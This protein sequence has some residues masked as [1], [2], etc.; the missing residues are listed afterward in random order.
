[1]HGKY[2]GVVCHSLLQ[3]DC[4]TWTIK[5]AKHQRIDAIKLQ[6]SRRLLKVLWTARRSNYSILEEINPE[7]SLEG[8]MLKLQYFGHI[9]QRADQYF[10]HITQRANSLEMSLLL[11]KMEGRGWD[12][13]MASLMQWSWTWANFRRRWGTERPGVLQSMGSQRVGRNLATKQQQQTEEK[14][15]CFMIGRELISCHWPWACQ[16]CFPLIINY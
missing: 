4:E 8:L 12:G 3:N 2:T 6:C 9:T 16:M 5:K 10:G 11:G 1:M 7:Y 14:L 15:S 13:W